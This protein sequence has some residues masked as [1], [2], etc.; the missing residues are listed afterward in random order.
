MDEASVTVKEE[1]DQLDKNV[2][3]ILEQINTTFQVRE[4]EKERVGG[5]PRMVGGGVTR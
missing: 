1:I 4:E 2:D 3:K 5:I